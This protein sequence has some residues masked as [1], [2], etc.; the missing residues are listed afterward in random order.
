[1]NSKIFPLVLKRISL[2][3]ATAVPLHVVLNISHGL[4][5]D[6]PTMNSSLVRYDSYYSHKPY[7]TS[8]PPFSSTKGYL[9]SIM[10]ISKI[11][12]IQ[13]QLTH[14]FTNGDLTN[15]KTLAYQSLVNIPPAQIRSPLR[16]VREETPVPATR[17]L[18]SATVLP[19]KPALFS[20]SVRNI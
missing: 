17:T 4:I 8:E 1:M 5:C 12:Y 15:G 2:N 20:S 18:S 14:N 9:P 19:A 10:S 7:G 6:N 16:P 3:S 11:Q 13:Q